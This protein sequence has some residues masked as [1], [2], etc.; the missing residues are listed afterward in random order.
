VIEKITNW[1]TVG[2]IFDVT[3]ILVLA[4]AL[5]LQSDR[6]ILSKSQ[7]NWDYNISLLQ[8]FCEQRADATVGTLFLVFGFFG[9]LLSPVL[10]GDLPILIACVASAWALLALYGA[11]LRS[12]IVNRKVARLKLLDAEQFPPA[13]PTPARSAGRAFQ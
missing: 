1:N 13:N 11:K 3:G 12:V 7:T 8:D 9:Q 5:I 6:H 10:H 2:L 4:Y